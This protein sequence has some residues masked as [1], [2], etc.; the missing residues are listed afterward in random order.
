MQNLLKG[1]GTLSLLANTDTV[2]VAAQA[3][4]Y[5]ARVRVLN[6]DN[7]THNYYLKAAAQKI[8]RLPNIPAGQ[9]AEFGP[10]AT[11]AADALSIGLDE[12]STTAS[13]WVVTGEV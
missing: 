2:V 7:V 10:F 12:A 8:D 9:A 6:L 5:M 1:K 13:P 3:A 11:A 4:D